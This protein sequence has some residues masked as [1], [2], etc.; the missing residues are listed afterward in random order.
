MKDF[1]RAMKLSLIYGMIGAVAAPL[2]YEIYANISRTFA[3]LLLAAW[4]VYAGYKLSS[5][6][7]TA[8]MLAASATL[9]YTAGMGF[10]LF[11]VIHPVIVKALEKSSKY[12][13]LTLDEQLNF[14]I[15]AFFIMLIM[16]LVCGAVWGVKYAISHIRSN[17][18]RA[19]GYIDNA[20]DSEDEK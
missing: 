14:V 6:S 5:L 7:R 17:N 12:F 9:A 3:L 8:A 13:Y 16:F 15:C 1:E 2:I 10:I 20:F 11:I 4:A 18:E 19:A